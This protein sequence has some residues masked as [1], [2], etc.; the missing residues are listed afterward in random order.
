MIEAMNQFIER[1]NQIKDTLE[2]EEATKTA[3]IMPFFSMLGYDVFN[4]NEFIPEFTADVGIKKGEKVDYAIRINGK[5]VMVIEAKKVGTNL[6][7][8]DSQLTRYFHVTEASIA[9]MT[10][11]LVYRF[12]SDLDK[13]HVMDALPFFEFDLMSLSTPQIQNIEKFKK[14]C[15]DVADI[16]SLASNLKSVTLVRDKIEKEFMNPSDELIKF[17]ITDIHEGT[18]TK[19]VLEKYA[20]IVKKSFQQLVN[21][22]V[23]LRL[24]NAINTF[25]EEEV[26]IEDVNKVITT[27]EEIQFYQIVRSLIMEHVELGR[28]SYRDTESYFNV[29]LDDNGRKWI[30]RVKFIKDGMN[31]YL[32]DGATTLKAATL[33]EVFQYKDHFINCLKKILN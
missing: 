14:E 5:V 26:A 30:C 17:L 11:G 24:N 18:K 25:S 13:S 27:N 1:A 3:L 10:D 6:T 20:P 28:I 12:Y 9:V 15:F 2:T 22:K 23:T 8:V 16:L 7:K 4:P 21:D 29:L 33:N 19:V 32:N 31:I